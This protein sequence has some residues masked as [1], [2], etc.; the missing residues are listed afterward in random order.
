MSSSTSPQ[1]SRIHR[2]GIVAVVLAAGIA[3][4]TS[5]F[6]SASTALGRT[7]SRA[8]TNRLSHFFS[9]M[10][11]NSDAMTP[12]QRQGVLST[13]Q[14]GADSVQLSRHGAV[15]HAIAV[16]KVA[17]KE[18]VANLTSGTATSGEGLPTL[19]KLRNVVKMHETG[20]GT[21]DAQVFN[22]RG[23]LVRRLTAVRS[24]PLACAAAV[25]GAIGAATAA[26]AACAAAATATGPGAV[27]VCSTGAG[28]AAT[29]GAGA[30]AICSQPPAP[31]KPCAQ[32]NV[33]WGSGLAPGG[34]DM[35]I[36]VGDRNGNFNECLGAVSGYS[37]GAPPAVPPGQCVPDGQPGQ[38]HCGDQGVYGPGVTYN[39]TV[40]MSMQISGA[41]GGT[42][43]GSCTLHGL[44]SSCH[45]EF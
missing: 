25:V 39:E 10:A 41:G 19:M 15:F 45:V 12:R 11:P 4:A 8:D 34:F 23:E 36:A 28:L 26:A 30:G 9:V 32:A 38:V 6:A 42:Y 5:P 17:A 21:F 18:W 40:V 27:P 24:S 33:V 1:P 20:P 3:A 35:A 44:G 7:S 29:A 14:S 43:T 22:A 37:T 16:R 31:P 13:V 2:I